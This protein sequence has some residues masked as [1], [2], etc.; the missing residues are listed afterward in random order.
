MVDGG[1]GAVPIWQ[2]DQWDAADAHR[3]R[4][5]L[6]AIAAT[7][8][9]WIYPSLLAWFLM[10]VGV[11]G[12]SSDSGVTVGMLGGGAEGLASFVSGLVIEVLA[13][14]SLVFVARWALGR[15][16]AA[17]VVGI[18]ATVWLQL[19]VTWAVLV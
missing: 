14:A 12:L 6:L 15:R 17:V 8:A 18:G 7:A 5:R 19:L 16:R 3:S 13:G 1:P 4:W 10:M 11:G 2:Q 9:A